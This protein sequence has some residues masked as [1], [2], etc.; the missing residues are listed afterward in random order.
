MKA[1]AFAFGVLLGVVM[2]H[3]WMAESIRRYDACIEYPS[4]PD[5]C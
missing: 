3:A 5:W 2:L 1:L 4:R